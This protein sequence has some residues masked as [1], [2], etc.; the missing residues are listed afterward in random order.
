[1]DRYRAIPGCLVSLSLR[2]PVQLCDNARLKFGSH[3]AF[4]R[5]QAQTP[6]VLSFISR[7]AGSTSSLSER[8]GPL[9][10]GIGSVSA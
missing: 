9:S 10:I 4:I 2:R 8:A 1:E 7:I 3:P 5:Q 6:T